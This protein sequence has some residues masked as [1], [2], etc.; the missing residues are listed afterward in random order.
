MRTTSSAGVPARGGAT[1]SA[2]RGACSAST[3]RPDAASADG[4][5]ADGRSRR[6]SLPGSSRPARTRSRPRNGSPRVSSG[7]PAGAPPGAAPGFGDRRRERPVAVSSPARKSSAARPRCCRGGYG[8][9]R[10]RASSVSPV[11]NGSPARARRASVNRARSRTAST[12]CPTATSSVP[13]AVPRPASASAPP[14]IRRTSRNSTP[15]RRTRQG[16]RVRL[17]VEAPAAGV[18]AGRP[19]SA[20]RRRTASKPRPRSP[21]TRSSRRARRDHTM[22]PSARSAVTVQPGPSA[23]PWR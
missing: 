20:G 8:P 13:R 7:A 16:G 6:S 10:A 19:R 17:R 5:A 9:S 1:F 11:A 3:P 12:R 23:G 14:S 18:A 22:R 21:A 15:A 4:T 2:S